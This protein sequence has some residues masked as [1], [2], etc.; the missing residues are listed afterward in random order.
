MLGFTTGT[1][2]FNSFPFLRANPSFFAGSAGSLS[3]PNLGH[4]QLAVV[5]FEI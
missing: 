2:D 4:C 1:E 3:V 5:D